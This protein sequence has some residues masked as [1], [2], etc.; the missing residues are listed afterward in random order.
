METNYEMPEE[1]IEMILANAS[2][3]VVVT[4]KAN[5]DWQLENAWAD[6]MEV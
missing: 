6:Y 1:I 2:E 4:P 3:T 5:V